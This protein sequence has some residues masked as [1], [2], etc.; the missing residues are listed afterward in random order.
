MNAV[1]VD[2]NIVSYVFNQHSLAEQYKV[3]L[4]DRILLIAAQ[5]LEELQYGAFKAKWGAARS[6]KLKSFLE[7]Y[8]SIHT[9]NA[10][11]TKSA[12]L[13]LQASQ[14]GFVLDAPDAWIAATASTLGI[15]LVTH[16]KK[17]F[18]FLEDLILISERVE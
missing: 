11:C 2:T 14:K 8:Q 1:L 18:D 7:T 16:N 6:S 4:D 17:H 13:R 15:P 3:H 9:T 10:I 5:T 12:E